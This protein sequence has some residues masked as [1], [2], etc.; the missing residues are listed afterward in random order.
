[1]IPSVVNP[2]YRALIAD[3]QSPPLA[4]IPACPP[5]PCAM[6]QRR[7]CG[8]WRCMDD[9]ARG[10]ALVSRSTFFVHVGRKRPFAARASGDESAVDRERTGDGIRGAETREQPVVE[11]GLPAVGGA[12]GDVGGADGEWEDDDGG[13]AD[14]DD[15]PWAGGGVL[16]LG[17]GGAEEPDYEEESELLDISENGSVA[18]EKD[19]DIL[20]LPPAPATSDDQRN[21]VLLPVEQFRHVLHDLVFYAVSVQHHLSRETVGDILRLQCH[22]LKYRSPYRQQ[23][24]AGAAVDLREKLIDACPGGCGAFTAGRST[25]NACDIC[26]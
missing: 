19:R 21:Q 14:E 2:L 11:A 5:P 10:P 26:K 12:A 16:D 18:D 3:P 20:D 23:K 17:G 15:G 8:C 25:L 1:M 9:G 13:E 7:L 24:L 6:S 4:L 22:S